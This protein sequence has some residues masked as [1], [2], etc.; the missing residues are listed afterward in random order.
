M[1]DAG[2]VRGV[3]GSEREK[4]GRANGGKGHTGRKECTAKTRVNRKENTQK[5]KDNQEGEH[6]K[7]KGNQERK[8]TKNKGQIGRIT[9]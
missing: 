3:A 1:T 7:T 2:V 6:P 5:T 9:H 8:Y 4:A